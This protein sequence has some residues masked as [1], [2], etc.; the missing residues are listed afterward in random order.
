MK[1]ET[2]ITLDVDVL[3]QI[4]ALAEADNVPVSTYINEVLRKKLM[5]NN[6]MEENNWRI[7]CEIAYL[8]RNKAL[9]KHFN[10]SAFFILYILKNF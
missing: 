2:E 10:M 5:H 1:K 9:K 4:T 3:E 7:C 6:N 8:K